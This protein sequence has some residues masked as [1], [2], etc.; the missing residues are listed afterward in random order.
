MSFGHREDRSVK[1]KEMS[2]ADRSPSDLE[3][4]E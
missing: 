3:Y 2:K 4:D 1:G